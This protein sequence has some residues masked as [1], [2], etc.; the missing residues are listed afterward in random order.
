MDNEPTG[1]IADRVEGSRTST[2]R[3]LVTLGNDEL[4][5]ESR[6]DDDLISLRC[7]RRSQAYGTDVSRNR[8]LFRWGIAQIAIMTLIVG[9]MALPAEA[10]HP[11][12]QVLS[13][14]VPVGANGLWAF[15]Q[16]QSTKSG[17]RQAVDLTTDGGKRWS[18]VTP[19][20]LS[21]FGGSHWIFTIY[22]L[23][24]KRAWVVYGG[25]DGGPQWLDTTSDGGR[26][27]TTVGEL[28]P[29]GCTLQ[30]VSNEDGT[31]TVYAGAMGSM[32]IEIFRTSNGGRSWRSIFSSYMTEASLNRKTP[33]GS[34]PFEC[35]KTIPF[36]SSTTGW[37]LFDCNYD[38]ATLYETMD[39]GVTWVSRTVPTPRAYS[40]GGGFVGTPTFSGRR[41]AVGYAGGR[42]SL[43]YVT[44]NDGLSFHRVYPPGK[45]RPWSINVLS[46]TR[47]RLAFRNEILGT[48]N[49]G[50]TWFTVTSDANKIVK[51][52]RY[53]A[54]N[55]DI[56][57]VT[58][59]KGWLT[60]QNDRLLR[61][62]DG[63]RKWTVVSVPGTKSSKTVSGV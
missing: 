16:A 19:P 53:A 51:P 24:S 2:L 12:A 52:L 46:A 45:L 50:T 33:P 23:T 17:G 63:G 32:G 35:D 3:S 47:W 61:T 44:T 18:I 60:T 28:P 42:Y 13:T 40:E 10:A 14:T 56:R 41:G 9:V 26:H 62:T 54:P 43:V 21:T 22:A 27:W 30:F 38:D 20:G 36:N 25:V 4:G 15:T 49:G 58:G 5:L 6:S 39:G 34:L 57:F 37:A 11:K 31:C 7:V 55:P 1:V 48:N 8:R 29:K 59:N